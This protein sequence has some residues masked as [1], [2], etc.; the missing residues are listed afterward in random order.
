MQ[1][2]TITIALA[3]IPL[4]LGTTTI[5]STMQIQP[6]YS[7]ATHC[8]TD[9]DFSVC[10]K[11]GNPPSVTICDPDCE[12]THHESFEHKYGQAVGHNLGTI[13]Q[14]CAPRGGPQSSSSPTCTVTPP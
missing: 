4:V 3:V 11:P 9:P 6:A 12:T 5:T 13:G 7:Q 14:I 10:E 1:K 8:L 2:L